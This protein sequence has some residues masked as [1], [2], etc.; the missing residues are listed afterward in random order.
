MLYQV[1]LQGIEKQECQT[2]IPIQVDERMSI[3]ADDDAWHV[4]VTLLSEVH[5]A[6]R[7]ERREK[8]GL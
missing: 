4:F 8:I 1:H 3:R 7:G 2:Q 5:V 6:V